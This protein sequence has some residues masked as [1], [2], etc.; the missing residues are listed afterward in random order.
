M[1]TFF[2]LVQDVYRIAKLVDKQGRNNTAKYDA[3]GNLITEKN[4]IIEKLKKVDYS[5]VFYRK[6]KKVTKLTVLTELKLKL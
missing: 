4:R 5:K 2:F 6:V 3:D 1:T